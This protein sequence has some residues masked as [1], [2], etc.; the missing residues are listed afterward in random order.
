[1]EFYYQLMAVISLVLIY[2]TPVTDA[3]SDAQED[4]Y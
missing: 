2:V 3:K 1:M 4:G